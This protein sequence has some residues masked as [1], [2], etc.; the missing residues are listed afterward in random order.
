MNPLLIRNTH[1]SFE[2]IRVEHISPAIDEII[3]KNTI[4]IQLI[5]KDKKNPSWDN[6]VKP[7]EQCDEKLSRA[8]SQISHLNSVMNNEPLR[9][10]YNENLIKITKYYS[11]LGQNEI[12]YKKFI[13]LDKASTKLDAIQKKII[14]NELLGFKL[15]G[16]SLPKLKKNEFKKIKSELSKHC[17]KFEENVLDSVNEF[18]L[19]IKD[20]RKL[21]GIPKDIIDMSKEKAISI[22]KDGWLFTLD[23]PSYIP[24]LQYADNRELREQLYKAYSIKASELAAPK[25]DN[26]KTIHHILKLRNDLSS[27][28]NYKNFSEMALETRM[29]D[30]PKEVINFLMDLA[31]KAKPFANKDML[32]LNRIGK[33]YEIDSPQAWDV[34]YLSEKLKKEKFDFSDTEI[35]KYFPIDK[36]IDGLFS[37]VSKIYGLSFKKTITEVWHKDVLFYEIYNQSNVL[38]GQFYLDLYARRNKRGGAWMDEAVSK[39]TFDDESSLPIA[40]LTC[41]FT[42]PIKNIGAYLNHDEIITLFHEF[43]HGLHHLLTEIDYYSVSGIKGVEW[44]A[45]ELPSQF[46]ENF[47]WEWSVIESMTEN[48]TTKKKMPK[49][50]FNKLLKSKNF[51]SGLQTLRQVEFS[52]FDIKL[53]NISYKVNQDFLSLLEE[54]R[55]EVA[56]IRPPKWNRFSHSFSHIFAGGY[57]A[58]YYSYKWAE[59][60]SADVYSMF[61]EEGILSKNIGD[62][63]K[64]EVLSKGGSRAAL[65]SFVAFRGRPPSI[66]AL[67]KHQGLKV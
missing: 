13:L 47:C 30:S 54:V 5:E 59:V 15:A 46:M 7:L 28:L 31:N 32:D 60:L 40:F 23:F 38:I 2:K 25:F 37:V 57:A 56:V 58:G 4:S 66:D 55:D 24:V 16:V 27:L 41:N 34:A 49:S 19:I 9:K 26:T 11:T 8:W 65:D 21:K 50:L 1:P 29:A 6:F 64:R 18:T 14:K 20:K 43:G 44:D 22:N 35:K 52:L 39:Y 17:S 3:K 42:A 12:I 45:V 63:F 61:E 36:V 48:M 51:Q 10:A 53:H 33:T 67:L 62:K